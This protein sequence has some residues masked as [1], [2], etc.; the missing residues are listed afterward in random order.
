MLTNEITLPLYVRTRTLGD[1]MLLKKLNGKKKL[2]DI[3]IDAKVPIDERD[4]WP[5]VV[6]SKNQIL[7][8]PGIKK[9]K[10]SKQ[11]NENYDIILRYN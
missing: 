10:F 4:S 2:K 7:W 5:V 8:I 11:K 6:D 3:F 9:S 1:K